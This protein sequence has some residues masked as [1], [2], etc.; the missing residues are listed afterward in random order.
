MKGL[1]EFKNSEGEVI[2]K[3]LV[4]LQSLIDFAKLNNIAFNQ[5]LPELSNTDDPIKQLVL[6]RSIIYCGIINYH[7]FEMIPFNQTEK[8][9]YLTIDSEGLMT[10]ETLENIT[11]AIVQG[12]GEQPAEK[13]TKKK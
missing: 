8:K 11:K 9:V 5:I 10:T 6:F 13:Q 7:E 2:Y 4:G 1:V 3:C 12:F